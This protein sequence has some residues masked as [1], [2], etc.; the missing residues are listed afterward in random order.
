MPDLSLDK[1]YTSIMSNRRI[2]AYCYL[3]GGIGFFVLAVILFVTST[4]RDGLT[5]LT[6]A[7][8]VL[9]GILALI[10]YRGVSRAS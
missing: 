6:I 9:A 1:E 2:L 3:L 10:A 4:Q 5:L 7:G 8:V